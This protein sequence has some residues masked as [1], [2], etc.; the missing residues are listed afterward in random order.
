MREKARLTLAADRAICGGSVKFFWI[1]VGVLAFCVAHAEELGHFGSWSYGHA[2]TSPDRWYAM[3][4]NAGAT[5]FDKLCIPSENA[6][7][8]E[9]V[10]PARCEEGHHS[11]VLVSSSIGALGASLTCTGHS[12]EVKGTVYYE[13]VLNH[14]RQLDRIVTQN[15]GVIGIALALQDGAFESQRFSLDG[16]VEAL[17]MMYKRMPPVPDH[18]GE[19]TDR[20]DGGQF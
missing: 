13:E 18:P 14:P 11:P 1:A 16:A 3:T 5:A 17:S 6:C 15:H 9:L 12:F 8:W 4:V 7:Y 10:S 2:S 19:G 20:D